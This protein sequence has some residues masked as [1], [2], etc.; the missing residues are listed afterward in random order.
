M[1]ALASFVTG[2]RTK[3]VVILV[4]I[5]GVIALS[6]LAAKLGDATRDET[7]SFLPEEAS[8]PGSKSCSRTGSWAARPPSV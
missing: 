6:P 4:W 7:A 5:V 8:P 2:R 3:W 1:S